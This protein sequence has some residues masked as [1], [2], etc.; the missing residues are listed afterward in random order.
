MPIGIMSICENVRDEPRDI[1]SW[2]LAN[3]PFSGNL[4]E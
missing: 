4:K 3:I 2:F 1:L